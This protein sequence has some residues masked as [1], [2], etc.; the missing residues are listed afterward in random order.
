[1]APYFFE[2]KRELFH[3]DSPGLAALRFNPMPDCAREVRFD[4]LLDQTASGSLK[5]SLPRGRSAG[6]AL[7]SASVGSSGPALPGDDRRT[8]RVTRNQLAI[9]SGGDRRY[10]PLFLT[11][12][13]P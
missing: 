3:G 10:Y 11:L 13:A 12:E 4:Q 8:Y 9:E 6:C 2:L 7:L 1:M 5:V